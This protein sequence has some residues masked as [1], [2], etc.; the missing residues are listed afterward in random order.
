VRRR[1]AIA[2]AVLLG[3]GLAAVLWYALW[4]VHGCDESA[5]MCARMDRDF[6]IN[7]IGLGAI[8]SGVAVGVAAALTQRDARRHQGR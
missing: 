1:F 6:V 5:E 4:G 3:A 7:A 2:A 8:A